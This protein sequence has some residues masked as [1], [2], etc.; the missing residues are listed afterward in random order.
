MGWISVK[1]RLPEMHQIVIAL[2]TSKEGTKF[3]SDVM[4]FVWDVENGI[5]KYGRTNEITHWMPLELPE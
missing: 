5:W 1:D 2:I 4:F 3:V